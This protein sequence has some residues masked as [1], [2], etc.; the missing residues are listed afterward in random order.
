M[1]CDPNEHFLEIGSFCGGSAILLS[2]AI[3]ALEGSGNVVAVD[4]AFNPMFQYNLKRAKALNV[5]AIECAGEDILQYY[6]NTVSFAFIDG[7]HSFRAVIKDFEAV[8][9]LLTEDAIVAFHDVSPDMWTD[10]A[11][12]INDLADSTDQIYDQLMNSTEED[13]YIDE[14]IAWICARHGYEV[15]DI[16]IRQPLAYHRETG[17]KGWVRGRTSPHN[18]FTAIRKIK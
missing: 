5:I 10:D 16:P 11:E 3:E 17:L 15:I 8:Q 13:F 18:A 1:Q 7:F 6:N 14:A 9:S 12:H 4:L 2:Y